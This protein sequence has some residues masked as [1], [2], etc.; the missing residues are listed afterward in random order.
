MLNLKFS[1]DYKKLP[2]NW[3]GTQATLIGVAYCSDVQLLKLRLPQL[4]K[5]DTAFRGKDGY[6]DLD[7]KEGLIL[8]FIH[9][10]T[11][12]IFTTIRRFTPKKKEYYESNLFKGFKLEFTG[13][14]HG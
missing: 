12:L 4:F 2:V 9:L 5:Y 6:Y 11:S 8:T 1:S 14:S 3:T 10:N 7:F 13:V